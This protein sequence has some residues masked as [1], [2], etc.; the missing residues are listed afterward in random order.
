M[1]KG[2]SIL[3]ERDPDLASIVNAY[4]PPPLWQRPQGFSTLLHII[5][6]Q[7]VSL[8]SARA[9]YGK[10]SECLPEISPSYFIELDDQTLK[11]VGFSRQ[12][13]EYTRILAHAILDGRLNLDHLANMDDQSVLNTLTTLKGIG[14]WTAKVYL[15]MALLRPDVWPTGDLALALA[16]QHK[17]HLRKPPLAD[18][19]QRIGQLYKPLRS[20]A[21]RLYW[22]SYLEG[23]EPG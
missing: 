20:V 5:L 19:L 22:W 23:K 17:K 1:T 12:K 3:S 10:L 6:E 8:A 2:V 13:T 15:L 11:Q 9:T 21:A 14:P 4:G 16:I 18:H 7:Q